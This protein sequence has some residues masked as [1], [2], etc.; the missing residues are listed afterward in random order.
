MHDITLHF[1]RFF[2]ALIWLVVN[3]R[4]D[5]R[6]SNSC[7]TIFKYSALGKGFV[8]FFFRNSARNSTC[9]L[10]HFCFLFFLVITQVFVL[11]SVWKL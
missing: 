10:L 3:C 1:L 4:F 6:L 7:D 11:N 9:F 8:S 2:Y 5:I